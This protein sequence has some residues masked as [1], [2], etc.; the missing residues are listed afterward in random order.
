MSD[1]SSTEV[2]NIMFTHPIMIAMLQCFVVTLLRCCCELHSISFYEKSY[3]IDLLTVM[4]PIMILIEMRE[5]DYK[6]RWER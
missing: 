3:V 1:C 4:I 5:H 6:C 2:E